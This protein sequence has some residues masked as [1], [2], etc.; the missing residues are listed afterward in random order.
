[1]CFVIPSFFDDLFAFR[2]SIKFGE[3]LFFVVGNSCKFA[4]LQQVKC[5]DTEARP[6]VLVIDIE[7][8]KAARERFE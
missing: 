8:A 1:M 7:D 2:M 4:C 3:K 5:R 6:G